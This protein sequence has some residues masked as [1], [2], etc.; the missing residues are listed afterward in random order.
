MT[1]LNDRQ[2]EAKNHTEGPLLIL[3][4]AGAGKTKTITERVVQIVK[5]GTEP[6]NILCITFTNKAAAEMRDR[7][8]KR[9]G[10]ENLYDDYASAPLIKTFHSLGLWILKRESEAAGISKNFTILDSD[11][12]RSI[13]KRVIE[14]REFDPKLYDPS[15]IRNAISREKA[16]FVSVDEYQKK[17]AS[18]TMEV[19]AIC[20]REYEKQLIEQDAVDFDDLIVRTV[21]LLQTNKNIRDK[22]QKFFKYVHVDEYQDTNNSQYELSKLLVNPEFNNICAV[23]DTD[24][25]IYSWRGANLKN[26][27]TFEKDFPGTKMILLEQN[28]RSTGNIL[29]LA[30]T[31]IKKNTIRKDKNLFTESGD[32]EKIEIIPAWDEE[33]EA[34]FVAEKAAE[35]IAKS[36]DPNEI[37]V[38]YRTNFQSR[39]LEE[40]MLAHNVPYTVLGTRF[41]ERKEIKDMLSYLKAALNPKSQPDLK[42]V[43][44]MPKRGVGKASIAKLFANEG[45]SGAAGKK[46]AETFMFLEETRKMTEENNKLSEI[47]TSILARSGIEK[48]LRDDGEE[49]LERLANI[50]ELI[51][52]AEK[53]DSGDFTKS[54][55]DFMEIAALS[56]DQDDD[57]KEL[58]GVRLMTVHAS[59]GLEFNTVFI[60]GLEEDLFPSRNFSGKQKTKEES[61]EERRLFYVAVTRARR[62]LFLTFAE[63]RTIFGQ[64]N[65]AAPSI[66]ISDVPDDIANHN[67]MYFKKRNNGDRVIF[68]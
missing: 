6:R 15:K 54:Y 53:Y 17:V 22:Y 21:R 19:V 51:T 29:S 13:V 4:G 42:R 40:K 41:F 47:L 37:A 63:M 48:E 44:E 24:Q 25:N 65:I 50:S 35:L 20:W 52:L 38:L 26:I 61:E 34:D 18:Y 27:M 32:G 14:E 59:K 66:F 58:S 43:F 1:T 31:A 30:N 67:D 57:K 7:I 62:Q 9:L 11:D 60:V 64:K 56:S 2:N 8:L 55:N 10:E 33:S 36:E 49:G 28:Y 68:I 39:V 46:I 23:G 16:D 3:A 5:N 12:S 45:I